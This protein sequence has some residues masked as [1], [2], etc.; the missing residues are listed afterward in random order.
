MGSFLGPGG[1]FLDLAWLV[2]VLIKM[3]RKRNEEM[4]IDDWNEE[5]SI[6]IVEDNVV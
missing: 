4:S 1:R 2:I 3:M 5:R 6:S